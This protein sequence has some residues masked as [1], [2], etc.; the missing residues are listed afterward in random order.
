MTD[1]YYV[2]IKGKTV[3]PYGLDAM[4]QLARKAQIGRS[5]EISLDGVSWVA[6]STYPEIFE[7]PQ[8]VTVGYGGD[9]DMSIEPSLPGY[10]EPLP[11][12][13]GSQASP[14]SPLWHYTMNGQQ[15]PTPIDQQSLLNLIDSGQVGTDDNVW[16]DTM[17][18]WLPVSQVP[19]LSAHSRSARGGHGHAPGLPPMGVGGGARSLGGNPAPEY[20]R[21]IGKKT[22]AGIVALL[23]GTLGIHKFM[24]GLTTGGITM[25][26]LFFLVLP[27]PVLSVIA[28]I[29]GVIYLTKSDEQFFRDY[30]VDR[31]QWF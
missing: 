20:Q 22:G 19:E 30:A 18:G 1:A 8:A 9:T 11:G 23:L 5:Y 3:G 14:R 15:Q 2:R 4:R 21:F 6:A 7:R 24:L 16:C 12:A 31:K 17:S 26:L 27:I 25:L 13:S 28:L 10:G 29:E